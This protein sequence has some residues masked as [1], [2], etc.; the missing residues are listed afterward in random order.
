MSIHA[1]VEHNVTNEVRKPEELT[2]AAYLQSRYTAPD[3][4]LGMRAHRLLL[5]CAMLVAAPSVGAAQP[6]LSMGVKVGATSSGVSSTIPDYSVK[7]RVGF[8]VFGY[9]DAALLPNLAV[10]A[11]L[12]YAA[13]GFVEEQE[14]RDAQ[15]LP[16]GLVQANTRLDYLSTSLTLRASYSTGAISPYMIAGPRLDILVS[17]KAGTFHFEL[18]SLKSSFAELYESPA[19]GGIVGV[20]IDTGDLLAVPI[21]LE[22]RYNLDVTDSLTGGFE[23]SNNAFDI[24]L[25]VGFP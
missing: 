21:L 22:A 20:G 7:R 23:M 16:L 4:R 14:A 13:R 1:H 24:L 5:S 6:D 10:V 25:G 15:N 11:E 2:F 19:F 8:G 3:S 12:G 17:R 18:G 9:V